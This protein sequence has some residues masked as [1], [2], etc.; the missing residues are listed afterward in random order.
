MSKFSIIPRKKID[1]ER[2]DQLVH[3]DPD[4]LIYDLSFYK[5]AVSENWMLIA[6]DELN[7]AAAFSFKNHAGY[8][9]I[10]QPFFSRQSGV[11]G[12]GKNKQHAELLT[13]IPAEF[14]PV[15]WCSYALP[16]ENI[17]ADFTVEHWKYQEL[18]ISRPKEEIR[19][20]YSENARRL[21]R[22]ARGKQI[23][24]SETKNVDLL[25]SFF[26]QEK[27]NDIKDL[28]QKDYEHLRT[29]MKNGIGLGY[30]KIYQ[31][32]DTDDR[33]LAIGFFWYFKDRITYLKGTCNQSGR[34]DGA[35]YMLFDHV[36][37]SAAD[38]YRVLDFGGS[39]IPSIAGFY[40]KFG[41]EDAEYLVLTR[42]KKPLL[43][44]IAKKVL[45]RLKK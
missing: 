2:W 39:R 11:Y 10:Y 45:T 32:T 28:K 5:D 22:K 3:D 12:P 41:A 29:L 16:K 7:C 13:V 40:K 6:N 24:V 26:Q 23:S 21:L 4:A 31:V 9:N 1:T 33:L 17:P 36:I 20:S 15:Q 43:I 44:R 38:H 25:I 18:D 8:K 19:S 37:L 34:S 14:K 35:M 30:G 27:G 42:G